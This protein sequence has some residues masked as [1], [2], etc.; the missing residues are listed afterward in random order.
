MSFRNTCSSMFRSHCAANKVVRMSRSY[1]TDGSGELS[2]QE[3]ATAVRTDMGLSESEMS[4]A[5]LNR[6]FAS[7][8]AD[9]SGEIDG[10]EFSDWL[11]K[12]R[13]VRRY[14]RPG[15]LSFFD[16]L[17]DKFVAASAEKVDKLGWQTLF[18][19]Y[20]TDGS[21]ELDP[22]EFIAAVR[23]DCQLQPEQVSDDELEEL[24]CMIDEDGSGGIDAEEFRLLL[25]AKHDGEEMSYEAFKR[26]MFELADVWAEEVSEGS[27]LAFLGVVYDAVTSSTGLRELKRVGLRQIKQVPCL[28]TEDEIG[29][30][31]FKKEVYCLLFNIISELGG[32]I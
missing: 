28:V 3:F 5:D 24:F 32:C 9:G 16:K 8:D 30:T 17:L 14:D 20:D 2:F 18:Q 25:T 4:E 15:S 23:K 7:V 6:L 27:Y 26:S 11:S 12:E 29:D 13:S 10:S 19:N 22:E 21:G 1:D 31:R